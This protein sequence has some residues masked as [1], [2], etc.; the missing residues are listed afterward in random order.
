MFIVTI[1]Q[2]NVGF[3]VLIG[4]GTTITITHINYLSDIQFL[5]ILFILPSNEKK[6]LRYSNLL[7]LEFYFI[8]LANTAITTFII[9]YYEN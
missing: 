6:Y 3:F 7:C 4:I 5:F 8:N 2:E 9:I 1:N